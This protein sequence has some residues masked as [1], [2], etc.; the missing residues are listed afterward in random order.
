M[1]LQHSAVTDWGLEQVHLEKQFTMLD[2]GCGGGRTIHKLATV[3]SE[4]QVYGIDYSPAS[5]AA[6]RHNNA[7]WIESGRVHIQPGSVSHLPFPDGTFDI[8]TAVE[9]HYYWPDLEADMREILRVLR[10]GGRLVVIAETYKGRRFD[11]IYRPAMML[12][13]ATYL[14]V[15]EH[16]EVLS[17]A[18]YSEIA[19]LEKRDK[20]W[21]CAV[22]RR[23][24]K[25]AA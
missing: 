21:I 19:V 6:A 3:A 15:G 8:V 9:T 10:P 17:K 23:P 11:A 22:G 5:V 20:G 4:G 2:V 25:L 12:L 18:G 16:R 7:E 24:A 14:S 1:N 13:R